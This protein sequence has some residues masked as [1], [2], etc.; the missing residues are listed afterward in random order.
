MTSEYYL[1]S[2]IT[3]TPTIGNWYA[4]SF[5]FS[6]MT[7][8]FYFF[9]YLE[10]LDSFIEEPRYHY[11]AAIHPKTSSGPFVRYPEDFIQTITELR[12]SLERSVGSLLELRNELNT[13]NQLIAEHPQGLSFAPLYQKING[14][15]RGKIEFVYDLLDQPTYRVFEELIYRDLYNKNLQTIFLTPQLDYNRPF[16]MSTPFIK[17]KNVLQLPLNFSDPLIDVLSKLKFHSMP[18]N[19][20]KQKFGINNEV[21]LDN[22][23]TY[24]VPERHYVAPVSDTVRVRY[25][26]HAT[27]SFEHQHTTI[28]SD[29]VIAN[30]KHSGDIFSYADLPDFIDCVII[31]HNHNDHFDFE[32]LIQLRHK[33][34]CIIVPRNNQGFIA[35]PSMKLAL[36]R[37]GFTQVIELS[38]FEEHQIN[39]INIIALPFLGEHGDLNIHSKTMYLLTIR[40]QKF[41]LAADSNNLDTELYR[42]I[43]QSY[44]SVD[45]IFVGMESVG[46]PFGWAY[47]PLFKRRPSKTSETSRRLCGSNAQSAL[48][49]VKTLQP[50]EVYAYAMGLEPWLSHILGTIFTQESEQVSDA[51]QLVSECHKQSINSKILYMKDEFIYD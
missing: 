9:R 19:L 24:E 41:L 1:K 17:D 48:E 51:N 31:T 14:K 10:I 37:A 29:P 36:L 18:L 33:I 4:W 7:A 15:I 8:A 26:G 21:S 44:G 25:F 43:Y 34:G 5:L 28:I 47:G 38:P 12:H 49:L 16:S 13:I 27:L 50:R 11:A 30:M 32:T 23:F 6:P 35:D 20:I 42:H 39:H 3:I 45:T 40:N 46:A 2:N 22:Y